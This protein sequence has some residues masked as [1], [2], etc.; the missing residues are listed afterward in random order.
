M[1][2]FPVAR[3]MS[4]CNPRVNMIRAI[5]MRAT[6]M[7]KPM[8]PKT[9]PRTSLTMLLV[10]RSRTVPTTCSTRSAVSTAQ[11]SLENG[12]PITQWTVVKSL[13]IPR[14]AR[15]IQCDCSLIERHRP[16]MRGCGETTRCQDLY[17]QELHSFQ[18]QWRGTDRA[19]SFSPTRR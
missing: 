4:D 3:L 7:M 17:W 19:P 10:T 8:R 14:S 1:P 13:G 9:M 2:V 11:S 18:Y 15:R 12:L 5:A 6:P 16:L